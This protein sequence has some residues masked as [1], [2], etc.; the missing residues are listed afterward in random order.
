M[1][2]YNSANKAYHLK[3]IDFNLSRKLN[4]SSSQASTFCGTK[5][6]MAPEFF[7]TSHHNVHYDFRVDVW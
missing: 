2:N 4:S 7:L 5:P 6:Y 3:I 1:L